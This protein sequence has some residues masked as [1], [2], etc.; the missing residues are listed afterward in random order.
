MYRMTFC[1]GKPLKMKKKIQYEGKIKI[2]INIKLCKVSA[3]QGIGI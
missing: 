3:F 1:L 2:K